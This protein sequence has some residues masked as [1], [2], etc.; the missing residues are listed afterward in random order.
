MR[1]VLYNKSLIPKLKKKKHNNHPNTN[2]NNQQNNWFDL[3]HFCVFQD[4]YLHTWT[5]ELQLGLRCSTPAEYHKFY[6]CLFVSSKEL[7]IRN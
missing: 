3:K 4:A 5:V 6:L 2:Q 1:N 7:D